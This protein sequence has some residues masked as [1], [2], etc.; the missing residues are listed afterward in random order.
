M[1][2]KGV[3]I[4]DRDK[5]IFDYL[6]RFPFLT[7]EDIHRLCFGGTAYSA[8]ARRLKKLV[9]YELI[10]R[11]TLLGDNNYRY[12]LTERVRP[13]LDNVR[14]LKRVNKNHLRHDVELYRNLLLLWECY[15][16][17]LQIIPDFEL[18][19]F[20]KKDYRVTKEYKGAIQ[21]FNL[22][23]LPDAFL[24]LGHTGYLLEWDRA[25]IE[26]VNL[27][28]KLSAYQEFFHSRLISPTNKELY[29]NKI[30]EKFNQADLVPITFGVLISKEKN[31][32]K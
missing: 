13:F 24:T 26:G 14:P 1:S 4:T 28:K 29:K 18:R 7:A 19:L 30:K 15:G 12:Y 17:K 21:A 25:T 16:E 9:D 8:A 10:K 22:S 31:L 3:Q 23:F 32:K 11:V 2:V 6:Q 5:D 20:A 27:F